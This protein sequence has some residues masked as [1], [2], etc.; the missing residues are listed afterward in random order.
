MSVNPTAKWPRSPCTART[1]PR[2]ENRR[3]RRCDACG[4]SF[5][6]DGAAACSE[7]IAATRRIESSIALFLPRI[8]MVVVSA[9]LPVARRVV[10]CKADPSEPFG[11]LP[12][13][14]FRNQPA[15]GRAVGPRKRVARELMRDQDAG[16]ERLGES[17][18]R[19]VAVS[20]LED[21]VAGGGLDSR[22]T[23]E[24]RDLH[25]LPMAVENRPA[26]HA[27]D[28]AVLFYLRHGEQLGERDLKGALHLTVD[29]EPEA[30]GARV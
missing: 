30:R 1:A 29:L 4:A 20:G 24:V 19:G 26:R 27:V 12:E 13:V 10:L 17:H 21:D 2:H 7:E 8:S 16:R 3:A 15:H 11:A 9:G 5:M 25:A 23:G 22:R 18:V 28:I 14:K 6:A